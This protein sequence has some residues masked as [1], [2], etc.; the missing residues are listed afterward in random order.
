MHTSN[1]GAGGSKGEI[2]CPPGPLRDWRNTKSEDKRWIENGQDLNELEI[3]LMQTA[4]EYIHIDWG[5]R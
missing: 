2:E 5:D 3:N 4:A 1:S